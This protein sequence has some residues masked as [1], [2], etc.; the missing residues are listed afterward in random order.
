M[1]ENREQSERRGACSGT[2]QFFWRNEPS[3]TVRVLFC[4][5][6]FVRHTKF[7]MPEVPRRPVP[8]PAPKPG[9]GGAPAVSS[10]SPPAPASRAAPKPTVPRT[11]PTGGDADKAETTN[12]GMQELIEMVNKVQVSMALWPA[13]C[14]HRS[15]FTPAVCSRLFL[16]ERSDALTCKGWPIARW[17]CAS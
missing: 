11:R 2:E 16:V 12:E 17:T 9:G 3:I 4:A 5:C 14:L 8:R 10:R 6:D 15:R 7:T 1:R 13:A